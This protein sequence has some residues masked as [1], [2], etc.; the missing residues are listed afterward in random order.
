[1]TF[2][3]PARCNHVKNNFGFCKWRAGQ[4]TQK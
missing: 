3:D 1:V 4:F 2:R